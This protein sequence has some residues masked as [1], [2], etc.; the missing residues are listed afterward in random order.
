MFKEN[1]HTINEE[2]QPCASEESTV[3]LCVDFANIQVAACSTFTATKAPLRKYTSGNNNSLSLHHY[4]AHEHR[5]AHITTC[6]R[7]SFLLTRK[8]NQSQGKQ[9]KSASFLNGG[10]QL[11]C[12]YVIQQHQSGSI[13]MCQCNPVTYTVEPEV[14]NGN[15]N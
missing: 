5:R 7:Y 9:G 2:E 15:I 1:S 10:V 6:C 13:K 3:S 11:A 14:G 12:L 8:Q 4:V